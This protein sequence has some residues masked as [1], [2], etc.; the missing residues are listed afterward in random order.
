M[1]V[2]VVIRFPVSDVAEAIK[3]LH[4]NAEFLEEITASTKDAGLIHHRFVSGAGHLVVIDEWENADQ[5]QKFF[6]GNPKVAEVMSSI[7]MTGAPEISVFE[8]V[9]A[10]GTV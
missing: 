2:V 10:A 3:G 1:S 6:D 9:D 5:F 8:S 7:G 4:A